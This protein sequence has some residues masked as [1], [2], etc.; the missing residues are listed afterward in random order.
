M[1]IRPSLLSLSQAAK[2]IALPLNGLLDF[3]ADL[4][5]S[6]SAPTPF[7]GRV[8]LGHWGAIAYDEKVPLTVAIDIKHVSPPQFIL[9][10]AKIV[11]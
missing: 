3:V 4:V 5:N 11:L 7:F 6:A 9:T 8:G 10:R 1:R 2:I